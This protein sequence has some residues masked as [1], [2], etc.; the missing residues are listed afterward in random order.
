MFIFV[1]V[2]V[3][4]MTREETKIDVVMAEK[5]VRFDSHLA[6]KIGIPNSTLAN[7][8]RG[9]ISMKTLEDISKA[10]DVTVKDLLK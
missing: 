9:D 6:E 7:R 5:G 3:I 2:N 1:D 4:N 8:L 10:L